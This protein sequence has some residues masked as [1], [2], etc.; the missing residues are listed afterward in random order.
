[1][2]KKNQS[3]RPRISELLNLVSQIQDKL[4]HFQI[5]TGIDHNSVYYDQLD[6]ELKNEIFLDHP[7]S[8]EEAKLGGSLVN[9]ESSLIDL[10]Y[11][12]QEYSK[13]SNNQ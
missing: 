12:L 5:Q 8:P 10:E 3:K 2:N 4:F 9:M 6:D 1:M 13:S 11:A 7:L